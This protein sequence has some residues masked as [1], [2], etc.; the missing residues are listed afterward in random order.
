MDTVE[1][2]SFGRLISNAHSIDEALQL[3]V[4]Q[5]KGSGVA[6]L[7]ALVG[8]LLLRSLR[9]ERIVELS[10]DDLYD[11]HLSV[12]GLSNNETEMVDE[13]FSVEKQQARGSWAFPDKAS[14]RVGFINVLWLYN[15]TGRFGTA[16]AT[17]DRGR[18][19]LTS[20][21]AAVLYWALLEALF[22]SLCLPLQL[23]GPMAGEQTREQ[24]LQAWADIDTFYSALGFD[25]EAQLSV[26]RY[27]GGWH[28]L[29]A[30]GQLAA[31][32][33]LFEALASQANVEMGL[34]YRVHLTRPL[35]L[36]YY[37]KAKKDGLAKRKQVVTKEFEKTLCAYWGGDW[38]SFLDYLGE[39]PHPEEQVVTALPK[40]KPL[41]RQ[42]V[43][44]E[45]IA[46]SQGLPAT[47][48]ESIAASYW[49]ETG[50]IS[51]VEARLQCLRDFWDAYDEIH[52]RQKPA[53]KPLWG[54]VNESRSVPLAAWEGRDL[55][56]QDLFRELLPEK[57]LTRVLELWSGSML[58]RW[59]DRIVT[60]PFPYAAMVETFGPALAFWDGC[61][62]TA[63][64]LCEGPYSRTDM[65]GLAHYHRREIAALEAVGTS[66]EQQLFAD[67]IEA[68]KRLGP[69]EP[70]EEKSSTTTDYGMFSVSVS[71][72]VGARRK[73]FEKLRDIIARHRRAWAQMHL[74]KYLKHRWKSEIT[75]AGIAYN[76]LIQAREGKAPSLKQFAK[77]AAP[78]TNHWFG[79]D[80]CGLFGALREK[81]P[82]RTERIRLMPQDVS[83]FA[84][85][86]FDSLTSK[87]ARYRGQDEA[88]RY[89]NYIEVLA[90]LSIRYFQLEEALGRPPHMKELGERF[91]SHATAINEDIGNVW[92]EFIEAIASAAQPPIST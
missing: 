50:G 55:F 76:L 9:G 7:D 52:M 58:P 40:V 18:V 90:N 1:A 73:G 34:R 84:R 30:A 5:G 36:N 79:G 88:N 11:H 24:Q 25:V 27:G 8:G 48:I 37:K 61:S 86:V 47:V 26:M 28:R 69:P 80:V 46:A 56:Q 31:K 22:D 23:R 42:T 64:F 91:V 53:M 16:I 2:K 33:L 32:R 70:I 89:S 66:V 71:T 21:P 17:E 51:P 14:L 59:P 3:E 43:R 45:E 20:T 41:V 49:R 29:N 81:C 62:L 72:S 78:A 4:G 13:W 74:E 60:E 15:Q 85:S 77:A 67:L 87:A 44:I 83:A 65:S 92:R 6:E 75:E 82:V 12:L 39:E 57:L 35:I 63:W 54:L 10:Q 68:E 38:L 19:K